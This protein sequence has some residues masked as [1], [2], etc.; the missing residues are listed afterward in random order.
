MENDDATIPCVCDV[1]RL[2]IEKKHGG[3]FDS[4]AKSVV[5]IDTINGER[6][7]FKKTLNNYQ[8]YNNLES[9]GDNNVLFFTRFVPVLE[10]SLM[11]VFNF[12]T[13]SDVYV[14]EGVAYVTKNGFDTRHLE[15][16]YRSECAVIHDVMVSVDVVK[17]RKS[18]DATPSSSEPWRDQM[19]KMV[20]LLNDECRMRVCWK[21]DDLGRPRFNAKKLKKYDVE[22]IG[23]SQEDFLK[24]QISF[25]EEK[26][27]KKSVFKTN[28]RDVCADYAEPRFFKV[29]DGAIGI[30]ND[31]FNGGKNI[32]DASLILMSVRQPMLDITTSEEYALI[33]NVSVDFFLTKTIV[34]RYRPKNR[35]YFHSDDKL[36]S[37]FSKYCSKKTVEWSYYSEDSSE[38]EDAVECQERKRLCE[39]L[40]KAEF[41]SDGSKVA[42]AVDFGTASEKSADRFFED[43]DFS[44]CIER[45]FLHFGDFLTYSNPFHHM[46]HSPAAKYDAAIFVPDAAVKHLN[47]VDRYECS[48]GL[49]RGDR[50]R[51]CCGD[52]LCRGCYNYWA[53]A[54]DVFFYVLDFDVDI[55]QNKRCRYGKNCKNTSKSHLTR[56]NH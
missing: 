32:V 16:L 21:G 51:H 17:L 6:I 26:I 30:V 52:F 36:D 47:L 11:P 44:K 23:W 25:L 1:D 10:K 56:F 19:N 34:S 2:I 35:L 37:C 48:I 12:R 43:A 53:L 41:S 54:S 39:D 38:S 50:R 42:Y 55:E 49:E 9:V 8:Q 5:S 45:G 31:S 40:R 15:P 46:E 33:P 4:F 7:V 27:K 28:I 13:G 22:P 20:S 29:K 18:Q 3:E 24:V 14:S